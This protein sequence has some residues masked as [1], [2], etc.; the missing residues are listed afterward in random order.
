M[1]PPQLQTHQAP[2]WV[3][4]SFTLPLVSLIADLPRLFLRSTSGVPLR[5]VSAR[6][7]QWVLQEQ[8]QA[9]GSSRRPDASTSAISAIPR[10]TR[11]RSQR[12]GP[13]SRPLL[14]PPHNPRPTTHISTHNPRPTAHMTEKVKS[15]PLKRMRRQ[16]RTRRTGWA[17][18]E[19]G[20]RSEL[21][22]E[23]RRQR[24]EKL[25]E[26]TRR[27]KRQTRR[28]RAIAARRKAAR[29]APEPRDG[30]PHR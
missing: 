13:G 6:A 20:R 19:V 27:Q 16:R 7:T 1:T 5:S 21:L 30:P 11:R 25:L 23:R 17:G 22:E 9:P 29:R 8:D 3:P 15:V 2:P 12:E 26:L 24:A 14:P 18:A 28:P 10:R 4:M